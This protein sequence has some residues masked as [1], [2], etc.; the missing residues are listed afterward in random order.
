MLLGST[1]I[2]IGYLLGSIPTAYLVTR[3]YKGVDIRDIDV[4]NV[5]AG[6]V[7]RTCGKKA[8]AIVAAV[9]IGKGAATILIAQALQLTEL[10]VLGA[11]FAAIVGHSYPVFIGFKGG[12]GA[13]TIIGEF[14]VLATIAMSITLIPLAIILFSKP[15]VFTKRFFFAIFIASPLLPVLIWIFGGS[16][17]LIIYSVVA[18]LCVVLRN[19]NRKKE[20]AGGLTGS[21]RVKR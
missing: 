6:A 8:G 14:M 9:D 13:A 7:F 16:I 18:I 5:G 17:W 2:I 12:Q 4:G 19:L 11:G 10:W 3:W 21:I 20:M 15:K 1:S